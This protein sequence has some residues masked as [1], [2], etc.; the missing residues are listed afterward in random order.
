MRN[1][2]KSLFS[3]LFVLLICSSPVLWAAE[4]PAPSVTAVA[5]LPVISQNDLQALQQR[6]DGLKQQISSANNYN[7]LEGPQDRVQAFI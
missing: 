2:L 3:V 5:P 4:L 7:Q 6:L 1:S